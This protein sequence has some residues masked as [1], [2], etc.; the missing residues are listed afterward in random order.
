MNTRYRTCYLALA[1]SATAALVGCAADTSGNGANAVAG[2]A[3]SGGGTSPGA[4]PGATPG[5]GTDAG[6]RSD[7]APSTGGS[8]GSGGSGSGTGG[9]GTGNAGSDGGTDAGSP[10]TDT[11]PGTTTPASGTDYAPYFYTWG[12]GN[13]AYPFTSLVD[14]KAKSGPSAA[15]LAFVLSSGGC[16]ATRDIQDHQADVDAYRSQG[17][18]VKASFGGANGTYLENACNDD[19]SLARAITE[20]V[21]QSKL[22]DLDFDVEQGGAMTADVNGRRARALK[23]VQ[24]AQGIQVAFTLA[25]T[26]RD[27]WG[28]PGGLSA[29]SLDVVRAAVTAGV[30][31]SHVNLMV[32]DYGPYYSAGQTMGALAVSALTDANAQLRSVISGLSEADGWRMLG[33]TPMIGKNDVSTETFTLD[34]AR[35]LATFAKSNKLGLLAFWAINRDQPCPSQDLGLCSMVNGKRFEFHEILRTVE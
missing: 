21:T 14:M 11:G 8:G 28:T 19:A 7:A 31:I 35:T 23:Q 22:K 32:M 30:R 6:A 4:T 9:T 17:G 1:I 5:A 10:E 13:S 3:S 16:A 24:S 25:A 20:F 15:T 26:P 33:A 12:W 2:D 18:R 27:K 34:D 29:A